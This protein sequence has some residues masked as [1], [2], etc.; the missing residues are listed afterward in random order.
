MKKYLTGG[1][2]ATT[3]KWRNVFSVL[4]GVFV[5]LYFGQYFPDLYYHKFDEYI[6]DLKP[7]QA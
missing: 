2:K 5:G 1:S 7:K 6:I 3:S 4:S